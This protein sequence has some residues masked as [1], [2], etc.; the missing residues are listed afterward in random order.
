[1]K[2]SKNIIF[3]LGGV[4]L[5]ID[6][7]RPVDAF[8]A[9]GIRDAG[10]LYSKSSQI[11]L[12]DNLEKGLITE[13]QFYDGIRELGGITTSNESIRV[14]WNSILIGLPEKNVQL[15][16]GLK[17][18]HRIFLL[19]NTNV[20]HEKAYRSMITEQYG[21]FIFDDLFEQMY[22]SH[23][24]HMRKPDPEIFRAVIRE[25]DLDIKETLF[26]DDSPQHVKAAQSLGINSIHL[27]KEPV[28]ALFSRIENTL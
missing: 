19:S 6:Y 11:P 10:F 15:L 27:A 26:I 12:F 5:D 3:D 21:S 1:M 14:A 20:I 18:T 13:Q 25:S 8:N 22:L 2:R 28:T 17:E 16:S 9:L 7:N 4:I 24:M 23:H